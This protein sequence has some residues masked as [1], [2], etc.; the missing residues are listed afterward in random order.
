MRTNVF[1]INYIFSFQKKALVGLFKIDVSIIETIFRPQRNNDHHL[2]QP[3]AVEYSCSGHKRLDNFFRL[4]QQFLEE[5][6]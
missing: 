2:F 6:N 4:Q 5:E 1:Q 3:K